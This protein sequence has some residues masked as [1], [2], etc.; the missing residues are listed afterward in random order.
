MARHSIGILQLFCG[1][2]SFCD[3]K[4]FGDN[5]MFRDKMVFC[6]KFMY[7]AKKPLSEIKSI[8]CLVSRPRVC[9]K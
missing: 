5:A 7:C 6:F 9:L 1:N 8:E 3:E 4:L 2:T